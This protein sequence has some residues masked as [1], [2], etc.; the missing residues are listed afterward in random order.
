[1]AAV[2]FEKGC[3]EWV[4]LSEFWVLCQSV[5]EPEDT[6]KYWKYVLEITKAYSVKYGNDGLVRY[7]AGALVITLEEKM[8]KKK[9]G[10]L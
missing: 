6:E 5:W 8:K 2:K 7:L 1:M 9:T 10:E 3:E 4:I